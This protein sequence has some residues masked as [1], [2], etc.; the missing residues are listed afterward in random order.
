MEIILYFFRD[1]VVG[2]YYIIYAFICLFLMFSII[3]YLFK[4]KYAK[5]DIKLNTSKTK[6]E[7]IIKQQENQV[8]K[9][10]SVIVEKPVEN[11][12][13]VTE[14]IQEKVVQAIPEIK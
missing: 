8:K 2:T 6:Q 3:G 5:L 11:I 12:E 9:E 4:Q 10:K 7:K 14:P 1:K 13:L